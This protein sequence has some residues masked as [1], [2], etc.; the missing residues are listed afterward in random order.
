MNIV[1]TVENFDPNKGYLEYY[2]ARE[3]SELGHKVYVFTFN[4]KK[5]ISVKTL[6]EGVQVIRIPY[7]AV[8]NGYHIPEFFNLVTLIRHFPLERIHIIHCQPLFSPLSLIFNFFSRSYGYKIVGSIF[9]Q[10]K[11]IDGITRKIYFTLVKTI[12]NKYTIK[13]SDII[14]VKNKKL[15]E[16]HK[17]IFRI[18]K[19]NIKIIALGA[20]SVLFN[21][22][23]NY[24]KNVRKKL[25][26]S[27][28]DIV[29][30]YSGKI[31]PQKRLDLLIRALIPII[32]Y[33]NQVKLLI[34]GK[35]DPSYEN[36]IK[37]IA[38]NS[39]IYHNII[40]HPWV[41]RRDLPKLYSASDIAVWPGLS[42]IS[43]VEAA[44][45]GLPLIIEASPVEIYGLE[46]GNGFTFKPG[47]VEELRKYLK[48]LIYNEELR[49]DMGNKSRLL[50]KEKLNWVSIAS[51]YLD[52]YSQVIKKTFPIG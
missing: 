47:N 39:G 3:L 33:N 4:R 28:K 17:K 18:Q 15:Y 1:I 46:Y 30:V 41:H 7:Y 14:F 5:N 9:T 36:D 45:V 21:Y 16:F 11:Q 29:I 2:L 43:I 19:N 13:N 10:V 31:N 23:D 27:S 37:L 26:L 51:Q 52:A 49:R 22:S 50:V 44:S 8:V 6:K 24:R 32:Q 25:G 12:V 35:G 48:M 34:I 38:K 42:S 20:D 40:F